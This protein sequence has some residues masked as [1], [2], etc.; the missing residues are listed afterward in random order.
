MRIRSAA[1]LA[2]LTLTLACCGAFADSGLAQVKGTAANSPISGTVAFKDV[3]GG[4]RVTAHL[5]GLPLGTHGFHIHE[6]GSCDDAGR[7]AGGHYNPTGAKHGDVVKKGLKRAHAG[8]L[9]NI[10]AGPDGTA[11]LEAVVP[12]ASL[13]G[14]K[15]D[16]AGR[17]IVV[18]EKPDD[19]SQPAGNAGGRIACGVIVIVPEV[20]TQK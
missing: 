19:F 18:Q 9:G 8:D 4:L 12:K 14:G 2:A 16:V 13:T 10:Q 7:A 6:F 15:Y 17:A 1:G 11:S 5:M 20:G 3:K